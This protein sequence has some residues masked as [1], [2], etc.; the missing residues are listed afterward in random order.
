[1]Y[2]FSLKSITICALC[3]ILLGNS[4]ALAGGPKV[5]TALEVE[6]LDGQIFAGKLHRADSETISIINLFGETR[7]IRKEDVAQ[8]TQCRVATREG[9]IGG[10]MLGATL[11]LVYYALT[12]DEAEEFPSPRGNDKESFSDYVPEIIVLAGLG[13]IIGWFFGKSTENCKT[14]KADDVV[15]KVSLRGLDSRDDAGIRITL[16]YSF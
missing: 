9:V 13:A 8:I 3:I 4:V 11:G 15:T 12:K 16:N 1:L 6:T 14:V 5:G 7:T 2:R 10:A